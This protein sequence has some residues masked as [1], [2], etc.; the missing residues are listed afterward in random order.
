MSVYRPGTQQFFISN[1]LADND[2]GIVADFPGY[3]FGDP[4][5]KPFSGDL[6]GDGSDEVALHRESTGFV[7]YRNTLTTGNADRQFFFGDPGDIIEAGDW[8]GNGTDTVAVYRPSNGTV[9]LK[10]KNE[11]GIADVSFFVGVGMVGLGTA[12]RTP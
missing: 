5:D 9:Y 11:Q 7:Y 4:G 6:D 12:P 8:D 10:L 3:I 1:T 2:Q